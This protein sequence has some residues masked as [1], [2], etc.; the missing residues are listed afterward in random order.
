MLAVTVLG[1][2]A[3]LVVLL[4]ARLTDEVRCAHATIMPDE[5]ARQP[6]E[7]TGITQMLQLSDC[8]VRLGEIVTA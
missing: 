4:P 3:V 8:R 6:A 2:W 7:T 1:S 5:D